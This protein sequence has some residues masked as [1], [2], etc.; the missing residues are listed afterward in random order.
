MARLALLNEIYSGANIT[1]QRRPFA[2]P[3]FDKWL[4]AARGI[5]ALF[6]KPSMETAQPIPGLPADTT[7]SGISAFYNHILVW[8]DDQLFWSD[9]N[10][11]SQWTPVASTA[12]SLVLTPL[13]PFVQPEVGVPSEWIYSVQSNFGM[14]QGQFLRIIKGDQFDFFQ[15]VEVATS[16]EVNGFAIDETSQSIT[17][18]NFAVFLKEPASFLIGSQVGFVTDKKPLLVN[19]IGNG[20]AFTAIT[21]ASFVVPATGS[22][23]GVSLTT[24]PSFSIGEYVSFDTSTTTIGGDIY[25]ILSRNLS[26]NTITV[27]R[28]GIGA[29]VQAVGN[30][31]SVG[32]AIISQPW[33]EVTPIE[34]EDTPI[35]VSRNEELGPVYGFKVANPGLTG[36]SPAG[37]VFSTLLTI[38]TIDANEAGFATNGG[39][40]VNGEIF[41]I[42]TLGDRAYI[43]KER[44]IQSMVYVGRDAGTFSFVTE[45]TGEGLLGRYS[46]VKI[47]EDFM[48]LLGHREM[49]L[50]RG[51]SSLQPIGRQFTKQ[52]LADIELKRVDEMV[53]NHNEGKNEVVFAYYSIDGRKRWF[54]YNFFEDTCTFSDIDP[55]DGV[56]TA[57]NSVTWQ[58]DTRWVDL[59]EAWSSSEVV[60]NDWLYYLGIGNAER[61]TL[62]GAIDRDGSEDVPNLMVAWENYNYNGKAYTASAETVDHDFGD[63]TAFKY[64]QQIFFGLQV[65]TLL[66]PR[67]FYLYV[68]VGARDSLD[69]TIRWSDP[70]RIEV[71]GNGNYSPKVG[72]RKSGRLIRVR[73]YSNQAGIQWRVSN[74]HLMARKG[75]GY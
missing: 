6:W 41:Q 72:V 47:G 67:P 60:G 22:S 69:A 63:E 18:D 5:P 50:Y 70:V 10:D 74:Y 37:T 16:S 4:F 35:F 13:R 57:A 9:V 27:Q 25:K 3:F 29:Q 75:G 15:V 43:F 42:V 66:S 28:T 65:K 20:E 51:G 68:Q 1:L 39:V 38:F 8:T 14:V 56:E 33:V 36:A 26:S 11:F 32:S 24:P 45:V 61:L 31:Y 73:F 2:V 64:L 48:V 54:I 21:S 49:Y 19:A 17:G 23:V 7:F 59:P 46:F 71:S 34:S 62:M 12:T 30:T 52:L 55:T 58:E 40:G 44:S 53:V